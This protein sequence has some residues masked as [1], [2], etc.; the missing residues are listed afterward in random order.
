MCFILCF[1]SIYHKICRQGEK[2]TTL[3]QVFAFVWYM[4]CSLIK[5]SVSWRCCMIKQE[6]K[7]LNKLSMNDV[8]FSSLVTSLIKVAEQSF[9]VHTFVNSI[10]RVHKDC[11]NMLSIA[12]SFY[13]NST[14]ATSVLFFSIIECSVLIALVLYYKDVLEKVY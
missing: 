4:H 1:A 9:P 10:Q 8:T 2:R 13:L 5:S 7:W 11:K 14:P 3:F 6:C 12:Q